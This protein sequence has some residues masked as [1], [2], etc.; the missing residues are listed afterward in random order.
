M[1]SS[2]EKDRPIHLIVGLHD[3]KIRYGLIL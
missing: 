1:N 2:V 3:R